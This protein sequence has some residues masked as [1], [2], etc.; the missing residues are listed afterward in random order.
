MYGF[1][2]RRETELWCRKLTLAAVPKMGPCG[3]S[4]RKQSNREITQNVCT[5]VQRRR[6]EPGLPQQEEGRAGIHRLNFADLTHTC[7]GSYW[8]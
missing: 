2:T 7:P 6:M 5:K 4:K 3:T 1:G 8:R